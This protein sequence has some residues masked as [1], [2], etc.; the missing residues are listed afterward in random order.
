[1]RLCVC[2]CVESENI[3]VSV[4][5]VLLVPDAV[6]PGVLCFCLTV[7]QKAHQQQFKTIANRTNSCCGERAHV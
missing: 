6:L 4:G 1:V 3:T 7:C 5:G 2:G